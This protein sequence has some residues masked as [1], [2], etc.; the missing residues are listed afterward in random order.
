MLSIVMV[1]RNL[2]MAAAGCIESLHFSVKTVGIESA[3]EYVLVDDASDPGQEAAPALVA[4]RGQTRAPVRVLR[5][6]ARQNYTKALA[7]AFSIARGE[8]ILFVSHDMVVTPAYLRTLLAVGA[9]DRSFGIIRGTSNHVDCFPQHVV[10]PP[11]RFQTFDD[12]IG[13]SETVSGRQG[14]AWEE[15]AFLIG[16][17]MLIQ[18]AALAKVGVFDPRYYGFFGDIDY[19]LRVRRAGLKLICAKG[20]W[21]LHEG[22]AHHKAESAGKESAAIDDPR[23]KVVNEAYA[24]FRQKWDLSLAPQYPGANEIDFEALRRALAPVGGEYQPRIPPTSDI[25]QIL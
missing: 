22:A 13:F 20:A 11:K 5:F 3:V 15:D 21:L 24:A 2:R 7:H 12:V 25:C 17:S 10:L 19:G 4:F 9:A 8:A 6:T 16:D 1:A 14:M 23:I 18:R